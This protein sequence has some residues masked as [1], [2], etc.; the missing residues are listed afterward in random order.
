MCHVEEALAQIA[1]LP[2][3]Q[4]Y[5]PLSGYLVHPQSKELLLELMKRGQSKNP[6]FKFVDVKK[7]RYLEFDQVR[8]LL[9]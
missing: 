6:I 5:D 1:D 3:E 7:G 9:R 2:N 8:E 4:F